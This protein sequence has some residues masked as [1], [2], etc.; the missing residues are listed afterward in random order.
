MC[1]EC[2]EAILRDSVHT[3]LKNRSSVG[4]LMGLPVDIDSILINGTSACLSG[5]KRILHEI[6]FSVV[7]PGVDRSDYTSNTAGTVTLQ[8]FSDESGSRSLRFFFLHLLPS[9]LSVCR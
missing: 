6:S 3:S 5:W 8:L 4:Y 1:E 2:L 9:R 7:S